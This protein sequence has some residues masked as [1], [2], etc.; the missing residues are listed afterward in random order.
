MRHF[1][2]HAISRIIQGKDEH[3]WFPINPWS[4]KPTVEER[5]LRQ[6]KGEKVVAE[7][8]VYV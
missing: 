7:K 1:I 3:P 2:N 5:K 6:C 8:K 4:V